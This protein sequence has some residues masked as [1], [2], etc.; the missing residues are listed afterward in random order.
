MGGPLLD[1]HQRKGKAGHA[2]H[3]FAEQRREETVQAVRFVA[4]FGHH[5]L[6]SR[7]NVGVLRMEQMGLD[8]S[9]V[10]LAPIQRTVEEPLDRAIATAWLRP[11]RDAQH[12]HAPGH[13]KHRHADDAELTQR[14]RR[15]QRC[16][17][18]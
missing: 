15:Q 18:L 12:R 1:I 8:Q 2:R 4:G 14:D 10:Q 17:A 13:G 5:H 11:A 16:Q 3:R 7:Q 9:P 6:I